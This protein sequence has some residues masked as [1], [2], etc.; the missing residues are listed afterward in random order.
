M[1]ASERPEV[2]SDGTIVLQQ[3]AGVLAFRRVGR[4]LFVANRGV[5]EKAGMEAM[6]AQTDQIQAEGMTPLVVSHSAALQE[7]TP[8]ARK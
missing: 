6:L 4:V 5:L 1:A 7:F 3:P 8:E 2:R